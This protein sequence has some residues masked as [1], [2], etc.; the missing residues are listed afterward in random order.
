M[1]SEFLNFI[2]NVDEENEN[3]V[4]VDYNSSFTLSL[5]NLRKSILFFREILKEAGIQ[6]ND[7][8]CLFAENHPNYLLFEQTILSLNAICVPRGSKNPLSDLEYIY[9][10]SCSIAIITDSAN[11]VNYFASISNASEF[12][13]SPK[14]ILYFG[15]E[16]H[17][18]TQDSKILKYSDFDL[19]KQVDDSPLAHKTDNDEDQLSFI[20]YT[21][22]TSGFPKGAMIKTSS[23]NHQI[24]ALKERWK[25][26]LGKTYLCLHPL[27][28]SGPK[29]FNMFFISAGCNVVYTSFKS[30]I[31]SIKKISPDYFHLVPKAIYCIYEEYKNIISQNNFLYK[32]IFNF[33]F[34]ISLQYKKS[35]RF[36]KNEDAILHIPKLVDYIKA[37]SV[38]LF[39]HPLHIIANNIFYKSLRRKI[40]KDQSEISTG[41]AKLF[42]HVEDFFDVIGIKIIGGYGLT[43]S[44]PLLTCD[45]LEKHKYYSTGYPLIE[46][47]IKVVDPVSFE[48]LGK[49]KIGMIL[50]KGPQIMA[51]Y[52]NNEEATKKVILPDGF[53]KTGDLGWL[54]DDN[55]LTITSRY[56]DVVVL[57]NGL[58]ID[59]IYIEEEC[60]KSSFVNQIILIGNGRD[61]ISALCSL[62]ET[63]YNE[64]CTKNKVKNILPNENCEFKE[65]IIAHLNEIIS[66]RKNFVPY[67][68]I[69]NIFFT[70]EP[71]SNENGLATSTLKL[72]RT[73]IYRFYKK[74]IDMM[75]NDY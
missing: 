66:K 29:I 43:E 16:E 68:S 14:L 36:I 3:N 18:L 37:Y 35:L 60:M 54:S 69:K 67:E 23:V 8:V 27:W 72:K 51:G 74:Q 70:A 15:N 19:S 28:H 75:Y 21:S 20:L 31:E 47:E 57:S 11:V 55:H 5:K 12:S 22:G 17:L 49:N 38:I 56:D 53:L 45:N 63:N 24:R 6:M 41:A 71:F 33:L 34:P 62:N 52:Y 4:L 25:L 10:N 58:N 40:L 32:S 9:K 42:G 48:N 61:C 26:D 73:Q 30:F 59:V 50:A 13:N 65:Y 39:A 7:K 64:W 44:S 2:D 46:T 1:V